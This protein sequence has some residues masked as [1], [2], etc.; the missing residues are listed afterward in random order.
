M[1]ENYHMKSLHDHLGYYINFFNDGFEKIQV[2][3]Q[4]LY[5]FPHDETIKLIG[6]DII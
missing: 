2:D 6:V 3:F 4:G 1:I 5:L